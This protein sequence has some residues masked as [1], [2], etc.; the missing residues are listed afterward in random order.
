MNEWTYLALGVAGGFA[1]A[2][3]FMS[4]GAVLYKIITMK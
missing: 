1:F 2:L 4:V 3:F